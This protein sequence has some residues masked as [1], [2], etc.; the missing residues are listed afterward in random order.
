VS[1]RYLPVLAVDGPLDGNIL[2]V[3]RARDGGPPMTLQSGD[4]AHGLA[5]YRAFRNVGGVWSYRSQVP[6]DAQWG[7]PR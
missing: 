4:L 1:P 3:T 5:L 6:R 2:M 7:A